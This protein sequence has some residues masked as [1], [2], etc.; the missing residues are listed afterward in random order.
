MIAQLLPCHSEVAV[1]GGARTGQA[2]HTKLSVRTD[3]VASVG[4][5]S[6]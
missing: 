3:K 4:I 1:Q 6:V 2:P 5:V